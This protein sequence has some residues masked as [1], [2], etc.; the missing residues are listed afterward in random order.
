MAL[1]IDQGVYE[2]VKKGV[3]KICQEMGSIDILVNNAAIT[4]NVNSTKKMSPS[5]WEREI[6]VNLNGVF[7][8]IHE[9]LPIMSKKKYGKIINIS[10]TGGMTGTG[11]LPAYCASKGGLVAFT[12]E[13]ALEVAKSGITV[14]AVSLGMMNTEIYTRGVL[15][16]AM[17]DSM[18]RSV[19]LGRMGEPSEVGHLV[20][21][22][23]SDKAAYI[24]GTNIVI[25]GGL[26]LGMSKDTLGVKNV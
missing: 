9:V 14:N 2:E 26:I 24:H 8:W 20:A 13:L 6:S 4:D 5:A 15:E 23:A 11:G 17:V 3:L 19:P 12:K 7:Y 25:D 1:K 10:S 16:P 22:L 18:K 21:F